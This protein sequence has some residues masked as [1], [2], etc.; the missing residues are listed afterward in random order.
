MI[1]P[2]CVKEE[3]EKLVNQRKRIIG[4]DQL[5]WTA[6]RAQEEFPE[7]IERV[8]LGV[9]FG[10]LQGVLVMSKTL[11]HVSQIVPV[12]RWFAKKGHRIIGKP[13]DYAEIG[14]RTW[15][16]RPDRKIKVSAFFN[17]K[18]AN[19]CKFVKTGEET[20]PTYTFMCPETEAASLK[21]D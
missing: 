17:G 12:L 1:H 6:E 2:D 9:G 19:S 11:T 15:S 5:A 13:E 7:V 14:R 21:G 10:C 8:S 3:L 20:R 18:D 16:L 4:Y